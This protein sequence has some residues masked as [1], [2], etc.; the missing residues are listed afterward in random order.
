MTAVVFYF[1]VHQPYRLNPYKPADAGTGKSYFD[2]DTNRRILR[3]VAERCYL[4]M[5]QILLDQIEQTDG[6]FRCAFSLSGTAIQQMKDWAPKALESFVALAE[7]GNVEYLAETSHHSLAFDVDPQEFEAQVLSHAEVI[8]DL[9]G[10]HPKTFR[11]TELCI[12][13]D[14]ARRVE[15]L[16]FDVLL[17]EGA[18]R[19]LGWR[20]PQLVYRPRGCKRLA[21]LLRSYVFSDDIAFRFSNKE[22]P[23]HP[24]FAD[25]FASWLHA[26][27]EQA[28]YLG[29]FMDYETFGEHQWAKETGILEFMRY[30][31]GYILED[32]RFT[33]ET[34]AEVA[35]RCPPVGELAIPNVVSWADEERSLAAW[36]GN[37]MQQEAHERLYALDD[38]VR[39][40]A[41]AGRPELLDDWR[42]LTTSDH[43]YYMCTKFF[44]DGDVH[45][46][47]TPYES[48]HESFVRFMSVLDDLEGQLREPP[49]LASESLAAESPAG[50]QKPIGEPGREPEDDEHVR[51]PEPTKG[52]L[53]LE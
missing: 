53:D 4:P 46:Y 8:E 48:P 27:P 41:Q 10:Q 44:S 29:L 43:V 14:L 17:G 31:P 50:R 9:F 35:A 25:T 16:G 47:F 19:L 42:K 12:D 45:K 1:Q 2:D 5:N 24:L 30:L 52:A 51:R 3:R 28:Q 36:L 38:E 37:Q 40:A 11:N 34:P 21:L 23:H 7:T 39:K 33:F 20:S 32:E 18:D 26:V 13:E 15:N 49:T 22:W 6:R